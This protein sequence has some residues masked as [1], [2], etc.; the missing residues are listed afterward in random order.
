MKVNHRWEHELS[1]S[2]RVQSLAS[3]YDLS[4]DVVKHV[5]EGDVPVDERSDWNIGLIVGPSGSGKTSLLTHMFNAPKSYVWEQDSIVDDFPESMSIQEITNAL[6][7]VGLNSIPAWVSP[8]RLLSNGQQFR[9]NLARM[10]ADDSEQ[11]LTVDEYSSVIDRQVARITSHALQKGV[12][13]LDKQIVLASC[14][15]DII[16]WLQPDWVLE[17]QT[18][19]FEWRSVQPRPQ[20]EGQIRRVDRSLWRKFASHHYLTSKL[21]NSSTCW[22]LF[23]NN[24]AV[25]FLAILHFAHPKVRNIKRV[26]RVVTHPDYQGIGVGFHLLDRVS[27]AYRY[28]G[29][30]VRLVTSHAMFSRSLNRSKT[31]RYAGTNKPDKKQSGDLVQATKTLHAFESVITPVENDLSTQ[32][33]VFAR[34]PKKPRLA[35]L[36]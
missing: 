18:M 15:Y 25:A 23:I 13:R 26:H 21:S 35:E 17:P 24:V 36:L 34:Q 27:E 22:G 16:E 31:W 2:F 6:S 14:H 29:W 4:P 33:N 9:A 8:Y 7:K 3:A 20:I 5:W 10:L 30:R 1:K 19:N 28:A 32:I 11:I 12:R